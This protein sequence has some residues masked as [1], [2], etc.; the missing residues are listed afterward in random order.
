MAKTNPNLYRALFDWNGADE[1][2]HLDQL[3]MVIEY[4]PDEELVKILKSRRKGGRK[5]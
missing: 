4:M 3:R 1:F 5:D 2:A